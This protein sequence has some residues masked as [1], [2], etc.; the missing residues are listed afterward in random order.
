MRGDQLPARYFPHSF[1]ARQPA[2]EDCWHAP[3]KPPAWTIR[4]GGP[5]IKNAAMKILQTSNQ[6]PAWHSE[7]AAILRRACLSF[8]G[9]IERGEKRRKAARY[10]AYRYHGHALKC[11]PS[12][13]MKLRPVTLRRIFKAWETSG[14]SA[15]ELH[16]K[17]FP[18]YYAAREKLARGQAKSVTRVS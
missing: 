3:H 13:R 12:R 11:D 18:G 2:S 4:A 5:L 9:R 1:F 17:P 10:V 16:Y 7:R 8:K 6:I 14:E 15:F